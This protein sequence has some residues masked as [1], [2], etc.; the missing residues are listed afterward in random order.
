MLTRY[1]E[2]HSFLWPLAKSYEGAERFADAASAY[3]RLR[4]NYAANPG[5]YHNRIECDYR[6]ARCYEGSNHLDALARTAEQAESYF[7]NLPAPTRHSQKD[8]IRY[9]SEAGD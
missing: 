3:E 2:S 7:D 8:R 5:N 6:L 9:L 1:P 4:T